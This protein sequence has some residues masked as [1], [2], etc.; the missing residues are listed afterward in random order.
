MG[1]RG[2]G[3]EV[4]DVHAP[5]LTFSPLAPSRSGP[6][7]EMQNAIMGPS[8]RTNATFVMDECGI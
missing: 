3:G 4:L 8:R 7:G 5:P 6:G 2:V 1:Q